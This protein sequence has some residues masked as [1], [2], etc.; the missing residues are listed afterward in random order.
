MDRRAFL[1]QSPLASA[2]VVAPLQERSSMPASIAALSSMRAEA[3]PITVDERRARLDQARRLMTAA[4]LD[5]LLIPGGSSL[6][7]FTGARW[8]N[9]ER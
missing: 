3:H 6:N 2:L 9:S 1:Q 5:A 7:Y 4:R 8:G